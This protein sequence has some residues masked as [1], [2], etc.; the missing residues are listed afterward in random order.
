LILKTCC[1]CNKELSTD[2]FWKNRAQR[3]GLQYRCKICQ[4]KGEKE[5]RKRRPI[6][7]RVKLTR[8]QAKSR[9]YDWEITE[10]FAAE[11]VQ[12]NCSYCGSSPDPLNGIDRIDNTIGYE[13]SNVVSCCRRCNRAKD[14]MT[15]DDFVSWAT[16]VAEFNKVKV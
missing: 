16:R 4:Y 1:Y 12:D 11:L 10:K 7:M 3:D 14:V 2:Q 8:N 13:E 15:V 6:H 5:S 9:G